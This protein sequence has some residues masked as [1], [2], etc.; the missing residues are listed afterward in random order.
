MKYLLCNNIFSN[1]QFGFIPGRSTV[2]QLL[3]VLDMWTSQLERGGQ[4]DVIYTDFEK[5]FDKV[6]HKRL[7]SKLASYGIS[8]DLLKWIEGFLCNRVSRVRINGH[9]SEWKPVISGIP[10]G[11]VLGP[12][13][14]AIFINDLPSHCS[15]SDIFLFAD[16]AKM[17][18]H[19]LSS[20]D[21]VVLNSSCQNLYD[22]C[23]QWL[24]KLNINKCKVL[25]VGHRVDTD[26]K[27]GF[28]I[29]NVGFV[30]LEHV[31]VMLDLGVM[32]DTELSYKQ[33][34]TSKINK[35]YQMIGILNRN[36]KH[37]SKS[38]FM[39]LYKCLIRSTLEYANTVWN[40]YRISLIEDLEKVQK[41]A[42]KLVKCCK[43][44]NYKER[45]CICSY[46]H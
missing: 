46:H 7:L 41:R 38:S 12:L 1:K 10:Q 24:M 2:L 25:S 31:D 34:I 36:F 43:N 8:S 23:E 16:D 18:K 3:K 45:L 29:A 40:P 19:I 42:T 11:S 4:I 32:V 37:L 22:W 15:L 17:F 27:Y 20:E 28:N 6:P 13:L 21:S 35:A 5:A 39:L 30:E 33:H 9:Q 44:M 14:F 26:F